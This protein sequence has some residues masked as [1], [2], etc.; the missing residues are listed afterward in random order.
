MNKIQKHQ[1]FGLVTLG[2]FV[3]LIPHLSYAEYSIPILHH[4]RDPRRWVVHTIS[5]DVCKYD[6]HCHCRFPS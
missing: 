3:G 6:R 5:L 4:P 1:I 2:L